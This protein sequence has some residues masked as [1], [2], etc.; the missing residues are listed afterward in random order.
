MNLSWTAQ[1]TKAAAAAMVVGC[2]IS[3]SAQPTPQVLVW[4]YA[5]AV[6]NVPANATNLSTITGGDY[7]ALGLKRDGTVMAWGTSVWPQNGYNAGMTNVPAGLTNVLAIAGGAANSLALRAD[8]TVAL[9]GRIMSPDNVLGTTNIPAAVTN[10][11]ALARGSGAWHA[12]ALRRDGTVVDWGDNGGGGVLTNVP[13]SARH[14]VSVAAG[15]WH[16]LALRADGRVVAW[17]DNGDGQINVPPSATNIVAISASEALSAA[18]RADGS[19]VIWGWIKAGT[20]GYGSLPGFTNLI[21]LCVPG[22]SQFEDPRIPI[23]GLRRNGSL[24]EYGATP[25]VEATNIAAIA[26][27]SRDCMALV[28]SGSPVFPD[29]SVDRTVVS[30]A[31]GYFR[32]LATGALPIAYQWTYN[33]TNLD[34][35]TDAV[36][37]VT[38]A[39][40]S[41]MGAY[42]V[43]AS[44]A[45]GAVTSSNMMLNVLPLEITNQPVSLV[46]TNS[47]IT[48]T[49]RAAVEGPGPLYYQWLFNGIARDGATNAWLTLTNIQPGDVGGYSLAVSNQ[50][51]GT[52]STVSQVG[53]V[54]I[55]LT[56]WPSN[57]NLF[58]G[59]TISLKVAAQSSQP[60]NYQWQC[61]GTNLL[62]ATAD[63]LVLTNLQWA[64]SGA[65]SVILSNSLG[66]TNRGLQISV[67]S[68]A[69]WGQYGSANVPPDATNFLAIATGGFV[70]LGLKPDGTVV[71]WGLA[72]S[73]QLALPGDLTNIVALALGGSHGLALRGDGTV[74]GWGSNTYGQAQPPADLT[75]VVAIAAGYSHSLALKSDGT[76]V[77]WGY[78]RFGQTNVPPGLGDLV[79][80]AAGFNHSLAL[81]ADGSVVAWGANGQGQTDVPPGLNDA[82]AVAGGTAH[83]IALRSDGSITNWGA[84]SD[85]QGPIPSSASNVV[86]IACG[87]YHNLAL[88]ADGSVLTWGRYQYGATNIPAGLTNAIFIAANSDDNRALV[89]DGWPVTGAALSHPIPGTNGFTLSIPSQC[90]RVYRLEYQTALTDAAWMPL[91]LVAGSGAT[92][93]LADP[94][95]T[96]IVTRYYRVRRW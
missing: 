30:G 59:A 39:Q 57:A 37:V 20:G 92:I 91:P 65:Y 58:R 53:V 6:T 15:S 67:T 81:R 2:L 21:D 56:S 18:L 68:V 3:S 79:M 52:I 29:P 77:A 62:D 83:S 88:R 72:T 14:I 46:L 38:N 40:P 49:L 23:L 7:H 94:T 11:V 66:A 95:S 73:P 86:A 54:P 44:N 47:G 74:K 13:T 63:T 19:A 80:V 32:T 33:G 16:G 70:S 34:G 61:N 9:W 17:G 64:Q 27:T 60:I 31:R 5:D 75:N 36:Y 96:N 50:L 85:G 26:V 90:G 71:G 84:T 87:W 51:G 55:L 78:N 89:G 93:A 43:V 4:G 10:V 76:T 41:Q 25:P 82:I 8:G 22:W 48:V 69:A 24:A 42:A 12:L 35:A 28:G 45:L 1:G